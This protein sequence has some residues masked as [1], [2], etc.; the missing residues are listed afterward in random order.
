MSTASPHTLC[1]DRSFAD[2]DWESFKATFLMN[3][4]FPE[5]KRLRRK[6]SQAEDGCAGRMGMT[7]P[8]HAE[9]GQLDELVARRRLL[10]T[11]VDWRARGKVTVVKDQGR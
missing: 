10:G 5:F 8:P 7:Q 9:L 1:H 3:L 11:S 6:L 2:Y 4:E